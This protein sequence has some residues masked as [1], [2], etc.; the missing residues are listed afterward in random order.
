MTRGWLR[1]LW[2]AAALGML[3][4]AC[5]TS[6]PAASPASAEVA[7]PADSAAVIALLG[8]LT[9]AACPLPGVGT[10]GQPDSSRLR[11]LAKGGFRAV[12]DLRMPDEPRGYDEQGAV[13][14]AGMEYVVLPVSPAT[15]GDPTFDSFRA[16]MSDSLRTP[17]LVHCASGN[18]V[19]ALML[20]WL[21]LDRGWPLERAIGSAEAGGMRSAALKDMALDYVRRHQPD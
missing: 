11:L 15:L 16:L 17:V 18:R 12:I 21:V 3:G 8:G 4:T 1:S 13:R 7:S 2:V 10:G 20:P 5:A 9:N 19:G 14:A 6:R